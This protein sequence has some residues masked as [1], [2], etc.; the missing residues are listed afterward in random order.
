MEWKCK[1]T[2]HKERGR[3]NE[4]TKVRKERRIGLYI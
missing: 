3:G 2:R 1:K 4:Y